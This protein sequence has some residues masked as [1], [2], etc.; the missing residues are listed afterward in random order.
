VTGWPPIAEP[1]LLERWAMGTGEFVEHLRELV[2]GLPAR[3]YEPDALTRAVGYPWE[4]PDGS[5]R[6]A[7][8]EVEPLAEMSPAVR[9]DAI[10]EYAAGADGR[11]PLLAIGSNGAPAVLERKFAH[12]ERESDRAALVLTGRLHDFDV[13]FA[14]QPALY[15]SLPATLFA[16]PGTATWV[17]ML[18]VTPAQFTQLAWSELSY[19]LG[20]LETR[21]EVDEGGAA[22]D[23]VLVFV[24]RFGAF[25]PAGR[26]AALAAVP[27][28][29]RSAPALTQ[30]EALDA[31][32][33]LALGP[34]AR[35]ESL[36]RAVYEDLG[37][38]APRIVGTLHR[39]AQQ[40]ASER[41]TPF[42]PGGAPGPPRG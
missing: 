16:S 18:W 7:G 29:G 38:L 3:R 30:E 2:A 11:L 21:F 26:P 12:L 35:A 15:G 41:W 6:L 27:A 13:G 33:A 36:V 37:S 10:G 19:R 39:Q 32:A 24:S 40:F 5:Y 34:D 1:E 8:G 42:D 9:D 23:E 31:A 22:F 14:A 4:R 28:S 25:C 20:R 17:S